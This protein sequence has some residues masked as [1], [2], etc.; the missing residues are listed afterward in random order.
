MAEYQTIV[1]RQNLAQ[2]RQPS[3]DLSCLTSWNAIFKSK[4]W[5]SSQYSTSTWSLKVATSWSWAYTST[6][7]IFFCAIWVCI[8]WVRVRVRV[9]VHC[10]RWRW[11]LN[12]FLRTENET[13]WVYVKYYHLVDFIRLGP[14]EIRR[15]VE[16]TPLAVFAWVGEASTGVFV[17]R[18]F[19]SFP[20]QPSMILYLN[21]I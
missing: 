11:A 14:A 13:S 12:T 6:R 4:N 19:K 2:L 3:N 8:S 21:Y 5:F 20:P 7:S 1:T 16:Q 18:S 9:E 15:L 17:R 10:C